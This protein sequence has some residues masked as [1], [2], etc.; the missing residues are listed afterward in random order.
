MCSQWSY[1]YAEPVLALTKAHGW[2]QAESAAETA[3]R[4]S[5]TIQQN[6]GMSLFLS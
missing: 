4:D 6:S 5:A 2:V 1:G 3:R